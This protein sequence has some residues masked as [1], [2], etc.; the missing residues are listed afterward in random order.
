MPPAAFQLRRD[1]VTRPQ[2]FTFGPDCALGKK[3]T[4]LASRRDFVAAALKRSFV[5]RAEPAS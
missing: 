2:L 3:Y 5:Q 1:S 4:A